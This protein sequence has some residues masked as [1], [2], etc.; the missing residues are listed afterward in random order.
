[1]PAEQESLNPWAGR[2]APPQALEPHTTRHAGRWQRNETRPRAGDHAGPC[3][4]EATDGERDARAGQPRPRRRRVA[5]AMPSRPA[6]S[7][8]RLAG[9]GTDW[10]ATL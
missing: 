1:M 4:R 7:N 5:T 3:R 8:A 6:P 9:S 2:T 10:L